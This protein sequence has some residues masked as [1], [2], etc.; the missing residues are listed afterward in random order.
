MDHLAKDKIRA[1]IVTE[2]GLDAVRVSFH[3]C[4]TDAEASKILDSIRK[5][6]G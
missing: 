6:Q 2:G 5:L 4:N 1:R 3:V